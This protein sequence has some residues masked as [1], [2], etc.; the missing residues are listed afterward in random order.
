MPARWCCAR[1]EIHCAAVSFEQMQWAIDVL[2]LGEH[3]RV[4]VSPDGD[5]QRANRAEDCFQ[6]LDEPKKIKSIKLPFGKYFKYVWFE[7]LDEFAGEGEIEN[8][9]DSAIRGGKAALCVCTYNPPKS[10]NNWVNKG[11]RPRQ[12]RF[13]SSQRLYDG[14]CRMARTDIHQARG[15]AESAQPARV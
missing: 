14:P 7:E 3:W 15:G 1:L 13:C 10:A 6:G 2:G 11:N 8:V 12:E 9:L 4:T 5:C